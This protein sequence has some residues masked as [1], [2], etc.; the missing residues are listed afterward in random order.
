MQTDRELVTYCI[1]KMKHAGAHKAQCYLKHSKKHELNVEAGEMTLLRTNFDTSIILKAII[2]DKRGD[3]KINKKDISSLDAAVAQVIEFAQS[4]YPDK[5][6][7]I[8]EKQPSKEFTAGPESPDMDLMYDKLAEF[9][10]YV[11]KTYPKTVIEQ[12]IMDFTQTNIIIQNSNGVDF[13][14]NRGVYSFGVMFT[15]KDGEKASS[16]NHSGFDAKSL[17]KPLKDYATIDSLLK[18]SSESIHTISFPGKI[19][20]DVIITPDCLSSFVYYISNMLSDYMMISG[21][22]AFK[23][24]LNEKIASELLT[25]HANPRS[26]EIA[27]N[28]FFTLDGF[29]AQNITIIDKGVLKSFLLSQNGANKTG[30]PRGLNSG[31]CYVIE[32]GASSYED[33]ISSIDK[34]IL[35]CRFSGGNPSDN[36][37]FSGVAKNSFL[38]ENG[39]VTTPLNETMIA[40]NLIDL[41]KNIKGISQERINYGSAIYPCL[42]VKGVTISG[43]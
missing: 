37:D 21:S 23:D 33:M 11:P 35:L 38:I 28:Y 1:D 40:G 39:K 15:S 29:E 25:L 17:D 27:K 31:G 26:P 6:N 22:S 19:V 4:S 20:G 13:A 7:D 18:Q 43:K 34:G 41:L 32:S 8:A 16:F 9:V 12:A 3:I 36:G 2:D 42:H 30:K 14:G 10:E 5:A 24:K